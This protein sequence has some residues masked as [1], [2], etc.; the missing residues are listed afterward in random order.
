MPAAHTQHYGGSVS[1]ML[2]V[3]TEVRPTLH[4]LQAP[5]WAVDGGRQ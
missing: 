2:A 1:E 4:Y 3:G 5:Y